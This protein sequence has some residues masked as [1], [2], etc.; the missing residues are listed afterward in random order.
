M[1]LTLSGRLHEVI[2]Q[3]SIRTAY[4]ALVELATNSVDAYNRVGNFSYQDIWIEVIRNQ[5]A[6]GDK[7]KLI[8]TDQ[9]RGMTNAE[10]Q[11]SLLV[12]GS[13][14]A[15]NTSR[16]F[17]G[18]GC[19]D[20][21]FLGDISFTCI[22][23][24]LLNKLIIY[25]NRTAEFLITDQPI[26]SDLRKE[27]QIINNGCRVELT[28]MSTLIPPINEFYTC[29]SNNV[30]LRNIYTTS[31]VTLKERQSNFDKRVTFSYPPRTLVISCDYDIPAY[32]TTAHLEIYRSKVK[33]PFPKTADQRQ[34]AIN[35]QSSKSIFEN[36]ALYYMGDPK[37]QDYI[38]N[39]N[40]QFISGTLTCDA[41]ETLAMD[42]INGNITPSNPYLI[43]DPNRRNGL[44]KDHPFTAALYQYAYYMLSIIVQRVQDTNEDDKIG[45]GDCADLMN[46]LSNFVSDMLP[47]N[48]PL[49]TFRTHDDQ[50]K[51]NL[52]SD[53][54]KNVNLDSDFL[55]LTWEQIQQLAQDKYLQVDGNNVNSSRFSISFTQDPTITTPYNLLYLPSGISMK[56]NAND[57]TI[58]PFVNISDT[59][60][61]LVN[62]GKAMT[63]VG[64]MVIDATSD[65]S[66][67]GGI[68]QN[69]TSTLDINA[70]NEY[71]YTYGAARSNITAG[72]FSRITDGVTLIKSNT[73]TDSTTVP[74]DSNV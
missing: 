1:E 39:P 26:N 32:N 73:S 42:A 34:F 4:E 9:A 36:S 68:I 57:P 15:S 3:N 16:G 67:R 22:R 70:F 6:N 11:S 31:F 17:I 66:V 53:V 7:V 37:V 72:V 50:D 47:E 35:V 59:Q 65:L 55:G 5:G 2:R 10:M 44:L 23:D 29:L 46:S 41:I 24:G 13:Y 8:I 60:V 40:I 28:C 51:L 61:N 21:S 45:N 74:V 62:A 18:R 58:K 12:V 30:Y 25:Q 63:T 19:K 64:H 33:M 38:Y 20:C 43:I 27:Y 52:L 14:T 69:Q 48:T 49:Y 54:M 56:I 71:Q